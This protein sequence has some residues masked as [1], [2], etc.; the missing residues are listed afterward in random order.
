MPN[1]K[2]YDNQGDWMA[3]CIPIRKREGD[4]QEQA[5]AV[6][7]SMWRKKELDMEE[8]MMGAECAPAWGATSFAELRDAEEARDA[9]YKAQDLTWQFSDLLSNIMRSDIEDKSAAI[10]SLTDEYLVLLEGL[11]K[12]KSLWDHVK[13]LFNKDKPTKEEVEEAKGVVKEVKEE[14]PHPFTVWKEKDGYRWLAVYSNKWRDEDNPPEILASAAHKEF[15]EAV[16]KGDWP[17]PE[18]WLWHIPGTRF[19][20][21]DLVT[22]DDSGFALSSGLVDKGQEHLAEALMKEDDLATSH[23][24]PVKEIERD[25]EDSTIITRYRS[26]EIS[27]LPREAAA[28]KYGTG[29]EILQEVKMSIPDKK[30]AWVEGL[31]GEKGLEDLEARLAGKAKE[32]DELEIQSKDADEELEPVE[33]EEVVGEEEVVEESKEEEPPEYV[34]AE[35]V[36]EA[37]GAYLR[38]IIEQLGILPAIEEAI[39]EQGKSIKELQKSAEEQVKETI[40]NTPAA[41]LFDRIASSIGSTE[42][43]IDGRSSLAK[44]GPKETEDEHNGPTH[45]PI[46]NELMDQAW[47]KRQ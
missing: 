39:A 30:R 44:A 9:A 7:L 31:L 33:Q 4:K 17:Y 2:K 21:A 32:L 11:P 36:A 35:E 45:V 22:Y 6:C 19:G 43:Y 47:S 29:Y 28:N 20:V 41:S 16:D 27:P 40:A 23:G 46:I 24:M 25:K 5:V 3:A 38:P 34:T 14:S 12:S 8:K 15:E 1:P 18:V 42:T 13:E 37:V 26:I 10:R